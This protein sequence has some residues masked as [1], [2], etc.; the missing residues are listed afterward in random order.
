MP[1]QRPAN[2]DTPPDL[3]PVAQDAAGETTTG[4]HAGG[5]TMAR[6]AAEAHKC[7]LYFQPCDENVLIKDV[8]R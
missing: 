6:A 3:I 2:P 7:M 4:C 8:K 1:E 5:D